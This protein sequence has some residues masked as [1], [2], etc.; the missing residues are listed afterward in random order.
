M[1]LEKYRRNELTAAKPTP[2][3][4]KSLAQFQDVLVI[5]PLMATGIL[6]VFWL[7][8]RE[9]SLPYEAM[10]IFAVV[11]PN[12]QW[13]TSSQTRGFCVPSLAALLQAAV[14]YLLFLQPAVFDR[15]PHHQWL[16]G[17][18]GGGSVLWF[19]E[20]SNAWSR[21]RSH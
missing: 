1:R 5:L 4:R 15:E 20:L 21:R 3:W 8:E 10:A 6:T 19:R 17:M 14:I 12:A 7:Y 16:V 13:V 9:S 11:L 2:R 18:F